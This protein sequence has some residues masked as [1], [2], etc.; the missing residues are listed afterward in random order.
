MN[1]WT[2]DLG[3]L[4]VRS[5]ALP[6]DGGVLGGPATA[7][8]YRLDRDTD[9]RKTIERERALLRAAAAAAAALDDADTASPTA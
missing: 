3:A 4:R 7:D 9:V 8:R 5:I 1:A 2:N 6:R